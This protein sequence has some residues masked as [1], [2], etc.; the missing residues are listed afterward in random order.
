MIDNH[1]GVTTITCGK[2]NNRRIVS[3][4]LTLNSETYV[5]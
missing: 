1:K 4:G 5:R 2:S 3:S